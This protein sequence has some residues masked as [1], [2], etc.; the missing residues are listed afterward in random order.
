MYDPMKSRRLW[1]L[2]L[3][4]VVDLASACVAYF[5]HDPFALQLAGIIIT[6]V[7]SI[8]GLLIAAYTINDTVNDHAAIKEGTHPNFPPQQ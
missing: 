5:V 7:T 2:I 8:G 3:T 1:T 6:A 4:L